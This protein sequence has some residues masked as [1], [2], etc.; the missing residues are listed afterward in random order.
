MYRSSQY[1]KGETRE[2][3]LHVASSRYS[4][5]CVFMFL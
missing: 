1:N 5:V 4:G 2:M 3:L